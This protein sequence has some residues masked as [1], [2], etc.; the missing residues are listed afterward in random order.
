MIQVIKQ[1]ASLSDAKTVYVFDTLFNMM[2]LRYHLP[3]RTGTDDPVLSYGED[4]GSLK[5]SASPSVHIYRCKYWQNPNLSP[6]NVRFAVYAGPSESDIPAGI[7]KIP[8]F[9][10]SSLS[11]QHHILYA[12]QE[13]GEPLITRSRN[14]ILIG[15]DIIAVTFHLLTLSFEQNVNERDKLGR[16]HKKYN[17]LNQDLYGIPWIDRYSNLLLWLLKLNGSQN[18]LSVP[19]RWPDNHLFSVVL[20]HDIDRIRTWSLSKIF[21][22]LKNRRS[23]NGYSDRIKNLWLLLKSISRTDSWQGN[24]RHILKIEKTWHSTF[25]FATNHVHRLDPRYRLDAGSISRGISRIRNKESEVS[26][27]GSIHSAEDP[28]LLKKEKCNLEET[29][30]IGVSG[31]RFHYLSF[32]NQLTWESIDGSG[33]Q[34]DTTLGF[35]E[36]LGFRC[37][38]SLPFRP[39][40]PKTKSAFSFWEVPLII[41]DTVLILESKLN[42]TAEEAWPVVLEYLEETKRNGG[43]LTLNFHNTNLNAIDPGG[44]TTLYEKI[45][46]W[47]QNH[48]GWICSLNELCKWWSCR[49]F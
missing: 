48:D 3:G 35:S 15:I 41:M 16:F 49:V 6:E 25:F 26:L 32:N 44:Y 24:F 12:D 47:S 2:G 43:C 9:F 18:F 31:N 33:F 30:G 34:Y 29:T 5:G 14:T 20:S 11:E 37:G 40:N 1:A 13:T 42:L 28:A 4:A 23:K 8:Y 39:Y 22:I 36:D 17:P 21:R 10:Y 45:L 19:S 46:Q 7:M 27:H 38:T